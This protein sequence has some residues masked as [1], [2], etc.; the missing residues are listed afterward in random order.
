LLSID[1]KF[2]FKLC[3]SNKLEDKVKWICDNVYTNRTWNTWLQ[4][5]W[6]YRKQLDLSIVL[7]HFLSPNGNMLV[8]SEWQRKK[9]LILR[10]DN[11]T[12][13]A[14]HY[15][16]VNLG[17]NN[18]TLS[19]VLEEFKDWETALEKVKHCNLASKTILTSDC[20]GEPTLNR[21]WYQQIVTWAGYDD[22]YEQAS[23]IH[24]K[25]Y[26]CRQQAAQDF[27][28]YFESS[29]FQTHLNFYKNTYIAS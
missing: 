23:V 13:I 14:Y 17:L 2:D 28:N 4:K 6:R 12:N 19:V 5:E 22:L 27:V 26:Q 3:Y 25:Y 18:Q 20:I 24:A 21:E 9:Q 11:Y 8:D 16:M 1:P 29:E 7:T 10:A 15:F